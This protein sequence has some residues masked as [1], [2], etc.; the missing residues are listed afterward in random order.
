MFYLAIQ[1]N[2]VL[3]NSLQMPVWETHHVQGNADAI[4]HCAQKRNDDPKTEKHNR[5][6]QLKDEQRKKCKWKKI[7][8][9][10]YQ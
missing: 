5:S 8:G 9:K 1:R 4:D 7:L 6:R 10:S 2:H 3:C